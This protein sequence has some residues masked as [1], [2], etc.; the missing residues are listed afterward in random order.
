MDR[1][2]RRFDD[3]SRR[4]H[5]NADD[6][7]DV[8]N[9][10]HPAD[11]PCFDENADDAEERQNP[12]HP[13]HPA[14]CLCGTCRNRYPPRLQEQ[15]VTLN[16][17]FYQLLN[18]QDRERTSA[19]VTPQRPAGPRPSRSLPL[20][21]PRP[22]R[23]R[24]LHPILGQ[25]DT[26]TGSLPHQALPL[27][28]QSGLPDIQQYA[29]LGAQ[30]QHA[31]PRPS[32]PAPNRLPDMLPNYPPEY[33]PQ[34]YQTQE[35]DGRNSI[36]P[37]RP[38]HDQRRYSQPQRSGGQNPTPHLR[39]VRPAPYELPPAIPR[40]FVSGGINGFHTPIRPSPAPT[41]F[42]PTTSRYT[43][44]DIQNY[45]PTPARTSPTPTGF[46]PT[47]PHYAGSGGINGFHTP[48]R[49]S[50]AP[51]GFPPTTPHYAG[52]GG[53]NN[54]HVPTGPPPV[55]QQHRG[56]DGQSGFAQTGYSWA[57][58]SSVTTGVQANRGN[59]VT[60]NEEEKD[61]FAIDSEEE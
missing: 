26:T 59:A 19:S 10:E 34:P 39:G 5:D 8:Q 55:L 13:Q 45:F 54:F 11:C 57:V 9:P 7:E 40:H 51:T 23:D 6:A 52:P 14:D 35:R 22:T 47:T 43:G 32:T 53:E 49:P 56:N 17:R 25:F 18:I 33:P 29:E 44:F 46:P 38:T 3:P 20:L 36:P 37:S 42:P 41:G 21:S 12:E 31:Q 60:Q 61:D 16:D 15:L 28:S 50:P 24:Y 4:Y 1:L 2:G 58:Q 27:G 30:N 48:V